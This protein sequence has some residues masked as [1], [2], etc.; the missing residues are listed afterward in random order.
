MKKITSTEAA[1]AAVAAH[2]GLLLGI[3][4]PWQ[5]KRVDLK[6]TAQRVDVE[7]EH[8]ASAE[9][10]C[11]ECGRACPRY[12]HAP[13]RQWRHLDVMQFMT[14]IHAR[15]PRCQ[16]PEHGVVTVQVPW[17]E[18]HGRFTLMF[19]AFAVKVIEAA[20][21]FVQAAEILQLDWHSIQEIVRRAVDMVAKA[22][23]SVVL[24]L[25]Y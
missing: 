23:Q 11:P 21:S 5:V 10:A 7:V 20:R 1:E 2:Y 24:I 15:T 22:Q 14:V 16:C 4:S 12:D 18:P 25:V 13:E 3:N 8:D 9:V 19:E 6:L 17:A